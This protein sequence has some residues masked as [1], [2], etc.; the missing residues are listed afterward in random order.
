MW[1]GQCTPSSRRPLLP[2]GPPYSVQ[3]SEPWAGETF[4][5]VVWL[6]PITLALTLARG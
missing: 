3:L 4:P 2:K 5:T 6:S 1:W